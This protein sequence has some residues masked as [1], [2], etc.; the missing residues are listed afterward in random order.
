MLRFVVFILSVLVLS[1]C[2]DPKLTRSEAEVMLFQSSQFVEVREKL[3]MHSDAFLEGARQGLWEYNVVDGRRELLPISGLKRE[4]R[5][6]ILSGDAQGLPVGD[7]VTISAVDVEAECT[8]I[9][10]SE[11]H[12]NSAEADFVWR[13]S[14]LPSYIK[15]MAIEGGTAK[16]HYRLFDDRWRIED[17][18]ISF[19]KK[20]IELSEVELKAVAKD[21]EGHIRKNANKI[22]KQRVAEAKR[23]KLYAESSTVKRV[24]AEYKFVLTDRYRPP[25]MGDLKLTDVSLQGIDSYNKVRYIAFYDLLAVGEISKDA[26]GNFTFDVTAKLGRLGRGVRLRI[27]P[28]VV[29]K[30][31]SKMV[32]SAWETWNSKYSNLYDNA[33]GLEDFMRD[34]NHYK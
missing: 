32:L 26:A 28:N 2:G 30:E 25:V 24:I 3:P 14:N 11:K 17:V 34:E 7:M 31:F 4:I 18:R 10:V 27:D 15:R 16:A 5:E 9:L 8:G 19:S 33:A 22:E 6:V 13:Y 20:P 21:K 23:N 12:G 29:P 1:A